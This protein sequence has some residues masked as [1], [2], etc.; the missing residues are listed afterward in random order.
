[1]RY[2]WDQEILN[3]ILMYIVT[4]TTKFC[5][6]TELEYTIFTFHQLVEHF[7][8]YIKFFISAFVIF[9]FCCKDTGVRLCGSLLE[10]FGHCWKSYN[11]QCRGQSR[12]CPMN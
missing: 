2:N 6:S 12:R 1:M 4:C 3:Q 8:N 10:I 9:E 5:V 7:V 11:F